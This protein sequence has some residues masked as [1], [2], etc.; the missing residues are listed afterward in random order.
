[1][2]PS[3]GYG[4]LTVVMVV[5]VVLGMLAVGSVVVGGGNVVVVVGA[6]GTTLPLPQQPL[7]GFQCF[8]PPSEYTN[9]AAT[10]VLASG[11]K[12]LALAAKPVFSVRLS[13]KRGMCWKR[14]EALLDGFTALAL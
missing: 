4:L 1:M 7:D 10:A 6:G 12:I 9:Q 13:Q 5:L 3:S 11:S 14:P 2:F 8:H